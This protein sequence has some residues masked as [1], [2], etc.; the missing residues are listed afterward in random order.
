MTQ[1]NV[2]LYQMASQKVRTW[3]DARILEREETQYLQQLLQDSAEEE[4]IEGFYKDIEFGTGG[5]RGVMGLG[6][7]RLNRFTIRRAS[8]ALSQVLKEQFP[9]TVP[10]VVIGYDTRLQSSYF[11][12]LVALTLS[13]QGI[14]SY[15]HHQPLAVP[16]VS[17]IIRK[18]QAQAGVIITASHNPKKYNG[19]K[20]YWSDGKQV[21][22]PYDTL[23]MKAYDQLASHY[24]T[25]LPIQ[26]S[27]L[28]ELMEQNTCI[29]SLEQKILDQYFQDLKSLIIQ[30][31]LCRHQGQLL[32]IVYTPLH[33]SG[34]LYGERVLQQM[35]PIK[36]IPVPLQMIPDGHFPTL[37]GAPNPEVPEALSMAT[38]LLQDI[39]GDLVMATDPD[40][41]RLGVVVLDHDQL[42][43]L[44]G[45]QLAVLCLHYIFV[46]K[47]QQNR[48]SSK[49]VVITTIV[50]TAML[51]VLCKAFGVTLKKTLTGFKWICELMGVWDQQKIDYDFVFGCEE[52]FGYLPHSLCRDKDGPASM[53]LVAELALWHKTQGRTLIS[54]LDA[55]YQ[56]FGLY[57][58]S[59]VSFDYEG[60]EGTQKIERIMN[61]FRQTYVNPTKAFFAGQLVME[62]EDYLERVH[63]HHDQQQSNR[64]D[65][66]VSNVIGLIL[67]K[68]D[69][70]Y[71]RPSGTE[72]K[73]KFYL[74]VR[75]EKGDVQHQKEKARKS[76]EH[77]TQY[78]HELCQ[79]L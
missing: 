15:V 66:P 74:M 31:E 27:S 26:E 44:N 47:Q 18:L 24:L 9:G 2:P 55:I 16:H 3:L 54:A 7:N 1:V 62:T 32:T 23:I 29:V 37:T 19:V 52:S 63:R 78:I 68:G 49:S 17:Y 60:L 12:K 22:P 8:L 46:H 45:N 59:L 51:D 20:V 77:Y 65:L 61:T 48:L 39:K 71:V 36:V 14:I 10:K 33:G 34:Y 58:E 6:T 64:I 56:E 79:R 43:F 11:A 42:H 4:I 25:S 70:I 69:K 28:D 76:L 41:D 57:L 67:D 30:P 72:P 50:T 21:T 73:I 5:L 40:S 38:H 53:S 35:G 75:E 13:E